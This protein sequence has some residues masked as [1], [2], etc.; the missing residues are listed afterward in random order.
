MQISAQ[1]IY[2]KTMLHKGIPDAIIYLLEILKEE[3][4]T[5]GKNDYLCYHVRFLIGNKYIAFYWAKEY[6]INFAVYVYD[7]N[8]YQSDVLS[9]A[10]G[11][12]EI[13]EYIRKCR[14]A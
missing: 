14:S 11:S 5:I 12:E 4:I 8:Y 1:D 9:F 13:R 7:G 3:G 6:P 2:N 10:A